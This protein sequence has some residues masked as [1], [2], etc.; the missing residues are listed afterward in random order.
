MTA[1]HAIGS[2]Q[3]VSV[4]IYGIKACDTMHKARAW[5]D[6]HAVAYRFHDYKA[7]GIEHAG[8][9]RRRN[10]AGGVQTAGLRCDVRIGLNASR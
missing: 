7:Q 4:T 6:T 9:G 10:L 5:L 8:A 1:D 2:V 3:T